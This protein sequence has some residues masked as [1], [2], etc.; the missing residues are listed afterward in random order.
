[1]TGV[2]AA[3]ASAAGFKVHPDPVDFG[4]T[5]S[6]KTIKVTITNTDH[7]EAQPRVSVTSGSPQFS[8][9]EQD[10]FTCNKLHP[11]A[12]CVVHVVYHPSHAA[13][14][15]GTLS[16]KDKLRASNRVKVGLIGRQGKVDKTPPNCTMSAK[17]N[18]Q[19]IKLVKHK[20]NGKTK[21]VT[22]RTPFGVALLQNEEGH[23]FASAS[24]KTLDNKAIS[25]KSADGPATAGN[26]VPL[27]LALKE[28]SESRI[29]AEVKND[30]QPS[31]KLTGT[32]Q[33][34]A[35]NVRQVHAVIRFRDSKP[36][37]PFALPLIADPTPS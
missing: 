36:G 12:K 26:G 18:Q 17:R 27:K 16:L 1:M 14:D 10:P 15:R 33:D 34:V 4:T 21:T 23:V 2:C 25:L 19:I 3:S 6:P 24:G 29:I 13:E 32:C 30:R 9:E 5:A 35:G 20:V 22:K 31:M 11:G 28:P 8:L 37:K 7:K